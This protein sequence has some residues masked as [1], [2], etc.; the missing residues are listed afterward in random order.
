MIVVK[1]V[2]NGINSIYYTA[3]NANYWVDFVIMMLYLYYH[4]CV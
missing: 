4:C 2:I 3:Q 1:G